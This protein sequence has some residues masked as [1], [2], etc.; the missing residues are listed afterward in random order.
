MS[1][2]LFA[3]I[4][5]SSSF[6][7]I[8]TLKY[9]DK[10]LIF[11]KPQLLVLVLSVRVHLKYSSFGVSISCVLYQLTTNSLFVTQ[12]L[13]DQLLPNGELA[14]HNTCYASYQCL[15]KFYSHLF[16]HSMQWVYMY[17][18]QAYYAEIERRC[19]LEIFN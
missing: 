18:S 16:S 19:V 6:Q 11:S 8:G 4:I 17:I 2:Q 13:Q 1:V 7:S 10:D 5:T 9:H 14:Q 15:Y 12:F 3:W